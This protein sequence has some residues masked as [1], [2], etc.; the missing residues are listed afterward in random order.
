MVNWLIKDNFATIYSV[1]VAIVSLSEKQSEA[2]ISSLF[3]K[4][5][6]KERR[7]K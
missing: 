5:K 2:T 6:W 7:I 4:I 3:E 1:F